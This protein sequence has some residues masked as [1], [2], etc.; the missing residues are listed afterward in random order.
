MSTGY[1]RAFIDPVTAG[2]LVTFLVSD[3][4]TLRLQIWLYNRNMEP[5]EQLLNI[6]HTY[7][8][9]GLSVEMSG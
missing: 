8:S 9:G 6:R 5:K 2:Y 1:H 7:Q 3:G 4:V